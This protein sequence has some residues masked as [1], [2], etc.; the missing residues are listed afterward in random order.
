MKKVFTIIVALIMTACSSMKVVDI[1]PATGHFPGA[2]KSATIMESKAID[3]DSKKSLLLIPNDD[4]A[5]GML[6]NIGYFDELMKFEDL[7]TAIIKENLGDKVPDVS[8][9]IG[10]NNAAKHYK[11]FLWLR[12]KTRTE[13]N[14]S[15]RQM[16]LTNPLDLEDYFIT[17][18]YL[19]YVWNGVNDQY[20]WY[21]MFN[22]FIDYINKN[23]SERK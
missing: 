2:A 10:I 14:K 17:E 16:I 5:A 20:N 21:P 22:A 3:L 13:G 6:A 18:T 8:S 7:E 9:K 11:E 12:F 23:S 4:F 19:D 15:Y 1:D